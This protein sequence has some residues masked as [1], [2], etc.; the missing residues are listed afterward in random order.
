MYNDNGDNM[1]GKIISIIGDTVKIKLETNVYDLESIIGKNVIFDGTSY[2]TD[3]SNIS[4]VK[5]NLREFNGNKFQEYE[6]SLDYDDKGY[7]NKV[8]IETR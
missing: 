8:T 3:P 5:N 2:G 7:V 6:I 4:N 1:L